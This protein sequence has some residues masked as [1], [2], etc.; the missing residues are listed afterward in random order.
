M[1][2]LLILLSCTA[3]AAALTIFLGGWLCA[4]RLGW[5]LG[6]DRAPRST[7]IPFII[8]LAVTLFCVAIVQEPAFWSRQ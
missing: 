6:P 3:G 4:T 7:V 2:P 1:L 8:A 5:V